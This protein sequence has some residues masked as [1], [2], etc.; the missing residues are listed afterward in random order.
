MKKPQSNELI[1][2]QKARKPLTKKEFLQGTTKIDNSY[3][4]GIAE[5]IALKR[6][7]K[8]PSRKMLSL[9]EAI[10]RSHFYDSLITTNEDRWLVDKVRG[11]MFPISEPPIFTW[12][13]RWLFNNPK[14]IPFFYA[15]IVLYIIGLIL[16]NR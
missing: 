13:D 1:K 2:L 11:D 7:G 15:L 12:I 5:K 8:F 9:K 10:T 6:Q 3:F 14:I 4:F 16:V